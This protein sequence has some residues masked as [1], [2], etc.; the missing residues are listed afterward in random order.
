MADGC[1]KSKF[2]WKL[3]LDALNGCPSYVYVI[4]SDTLDSKDRKENTWKQI[5]LSTAGF[6][7]AISGIK[8]WNWKHK[9][10]LGQKKHWKTLEHW[11]TLKTL[12]TLKT[13]ETLENTMFTWDRQTCGF[14]V[15][16]GQI[17]DF[18]D[19]G[20]ILIVSR[21]LKYFSCWHSTQ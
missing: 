1:L 16:M 11:K 9:V 21:G 14:V 20:E 12:E 17:R 18:T 6:I 4:V 2:T 5:L 7:W 3:F 10:H 8:N 15:F 13:W 19:Q